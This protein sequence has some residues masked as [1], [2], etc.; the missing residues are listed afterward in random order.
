MAKEIIAKEGENNEKR[1]NLLEMR[2]SIFGRL[3][4]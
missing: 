2:K 4:L 1:R 3:D